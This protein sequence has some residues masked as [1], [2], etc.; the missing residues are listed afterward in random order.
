MLI[1]DSYL[2]WFFFFDGMYAAAPAISLVDWRAHINWVRNVDQFGVA[3]YMNFACSFAH[4]TSFL[5][6]LAKIKCSICSYGYAYPH[7]DIFWLEKKGSWNCPKRKKKRVGVLLGQNDH[8]RSSQIAKLVLCQGS[9]F[10]AELLQRCHY[11]IYLFLA[12]LTCSPSL[13]DA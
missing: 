1:F 11:Y 13:T 8:Y 9:H 6:L 7:I 12:F 3:S 10:F 5:S 4:F 2:I